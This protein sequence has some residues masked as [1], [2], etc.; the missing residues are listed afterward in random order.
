[1][2][3]IDENM[4]V[5]MARALED[6]ECIAQR[7]HRSERHEFEIDRDAEAPRLL[8]HRGELV[9]NDGEIVSIS[10]ANRESRR[11]NGRARLHHR[12]IVG[13]IERRCERHHFDFGD[14]DAVIGET[15]SHLGLLGGRAQRIHDTAG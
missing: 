9:G 8:G 4:R 6:V 5:R 15:S 7:L 13:G 11:T 12:L 1:M 2:Q 14:L 10:A 3:H